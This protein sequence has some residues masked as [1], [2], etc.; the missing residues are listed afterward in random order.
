LLR[1]N[2]S[3]KRQSDG[4]SSEIQAVRF[5]IKEIENKNQRS[6]DENRGLALTL[7]ALKE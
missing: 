1:I 6:N 3:L 4:R 5:Q 2:T 7:K